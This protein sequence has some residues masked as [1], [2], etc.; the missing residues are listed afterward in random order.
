MS[1]DWTEKRDLIKLA[2]VIIT[3][4]ITIKTVIGNK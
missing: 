3:T 4:V 2:T 1:H